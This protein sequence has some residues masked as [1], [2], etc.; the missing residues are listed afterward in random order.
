MVYGL[1]TLII[2]LIFALVVLIHTLGGGLFS[3]LPVLV[4]V[5]G[6]VGYVLW[7]KKRNRDGD[8]Q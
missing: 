8:E 3:L 5:A 4:A 2:L 7:F 6:V 1:A